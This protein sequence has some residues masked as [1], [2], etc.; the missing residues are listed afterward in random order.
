[1][2]KPEKG[3]VSWHQLNCESLEKRDL[4]EEPENRNS[5]DS[6]KKEKLVASKKKE[7]I[8]RLFDATGRCPIESQHTTVG[9]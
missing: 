7:R 3:E 5:V 1:M 6:Q 9:K 4:G 2:V 8:A